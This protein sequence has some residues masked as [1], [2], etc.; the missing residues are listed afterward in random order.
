MALYMNDN[1]TTYFDC[2]GNENIPE[3][4]KTLIKNENIASFYRMPAYNSIIC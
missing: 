2:F 4:M 3:K 1:T